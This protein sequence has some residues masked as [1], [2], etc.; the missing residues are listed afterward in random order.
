MQSS[1]Y[2]GL[3]NAAERNLDFKK[4]HGEGVLQWFFASVLGER[5]S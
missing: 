4:W 2:M 1:N 3:G 5:A